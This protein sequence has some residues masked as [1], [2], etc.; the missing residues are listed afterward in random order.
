MSP[1]TKQQYQDIRSGK[2]TLI[3]NTA[4]EL[5][6]MEGYHNTSISKISEKAGISKGLMYNYF[7]S[8]EDL[9]RT[10]IVD[11]L[12]RLGGLLDPN[13]DGS[14]SRDEM[15]LFIEN[16]FDMMRKDLHFWALYFSLMTQPQVLKLVHDK[17]EETLLL[18]QSMLGK[19]FEMLE[20]EDPE[21]EALIF[22][23]LMDGIGL[24][25]IANPDL[26]P[27]EKIKNRLIQQYCS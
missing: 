10:I 9:I 4:M 16:S 2:K 23:A 3:L 7:E 21:T 14:I 8:K 15:K 6:A 26:F 13:R 18:Y 22:G 27:I 1:R 20:Y 5:F 12:E 25:F 17:L 11:G 19:Y 24:N